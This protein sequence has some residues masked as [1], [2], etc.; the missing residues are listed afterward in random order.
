MYPKEDEE[1]HF[2]AGCYTCPVTH[3]EMHLETDVPRAW[4]HWPVRVVCKACGQEHLLQYED[5]D[6]CCPVFGYE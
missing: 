3:E 4:V 6:Q 5:V 1:R 2:E